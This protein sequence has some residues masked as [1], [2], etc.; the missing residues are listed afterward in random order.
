METENIMVDL[1]RLW[2]GKGR[3]D[4]HSVLEDAWGWK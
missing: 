4:E 3:N 1:I 2:K